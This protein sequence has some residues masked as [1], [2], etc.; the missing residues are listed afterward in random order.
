MEEGEQWVYE[1]VLKLVQQGSATRWMSLKLS[2]LSNFGIY[3]WTIF[4]PGVNH[5]GYFASI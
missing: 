4:V 2:E 1:W 3:S 5:I